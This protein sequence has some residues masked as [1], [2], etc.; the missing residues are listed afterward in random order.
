MGWILHPIKASQ[1]YGST[2]WGWPPSDSEDSCKLSVKSALEP[3]GQGG[4]MGLMCGVSPQTKAQLS[5][6]NNDSFLSQIMPDEDIYLPLRSP[7]KEHVQVVAGSEEVFTQRR[8][9]CVI[10]WGA[11]PKHLHFGQREPGPVRKNYGPRLCVFNASAPDC[12]ASRVSR[13]T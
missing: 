12:L 8:R 1:K 11:S 7:W 9:S 4:F 10:S 3:Y 6:L 5:P 13:Y 2:N